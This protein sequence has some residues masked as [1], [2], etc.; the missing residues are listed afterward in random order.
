MTNRLRSDR[1][2]FFCFTESACQRREE[3]WWRPKWPPNYIQW[4]S[5][6]PL[7][8]MRG[9]GTGVW[10]ALAW[11]ASQS[12]GIRLLVK[13]LPLEEAIWRPQVA[14]CGTEPVE[15][16]VR[17]HKEGSGYKSI[18]S[19]E[20]SLQRTSGGPPCNPSLYHPLAER[21]LASMG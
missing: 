9:L 18:G 6:G 17:R 1:T 8:K 13:S 4:P 21:R 3:A 7:V 10:V 2:I 15:Q 14:C 5:S 11:H 20:A 16:K 19:D 12:S